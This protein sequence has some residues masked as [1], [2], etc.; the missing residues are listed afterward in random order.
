MYTWHV[1][2]AFGL[3]SV[4][5]SELAALGTTDVRVG[6]G[7]LTVSGDASLLARMQLWLRCAERISLLLDHFVARDFDDLFE[8][9]SAIPWEDIVPWD[10]RIL[11]VCP[12]ASNA[13]IT[14]ARS[15]QAIA[16]KAIIE[17]LKR[18]T[19]RRV[20]PETGDAYSITVD[21]SADTAAVLLDACGDGLHRRGYRVEP[22]LAP[23]RE[24]TAAA[25]VLLSGWIGLPNSAGVFPHSGSL[26]AGEILWDP[27]CGSG[28]IAIEAAMLAA[29]I[30]PGLMRYFAS[31][32]WCFLD[33]G[34]FNQERTTA[35]ERALAGIEKPT[36]TV[37][38]SDINP[39]AI[40][41]ADGNMQR[42][43][44]AGRIKLFKADVAELAD[45][46]AATLVLV[47]PPYGERLGSEQEATEIPAKLF[48][49]LRIFSKPWRCGILTPNREINTL[50]GMRYRKN[51]K[52]Y[53]GK[54]CV[55]LC[56]FE[57]KDAAPSD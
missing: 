11:I 42:A 51:R 56:W 34:V 41:A 10:A 14:S 9:I 39:Q 53:N 25:M 52:L 13:L 8:G 35:K 6:N 40:S 17:R 21:I 57:G 46:K 36:P 2:T 54:L 28:T 1:S 27:C 38:A 5:A 48:E 49:R 44:V 12:R 19:G 22:G 16:K 23:V 33:A 7:M 26:H 29:D 55:W 47:N 24:T 50:V 45:P 32:N 43:G 3:E 15:A 4:V 18:G 30:A 37:R 31:E 20:F